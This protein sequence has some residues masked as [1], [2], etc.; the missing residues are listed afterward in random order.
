[1]D[2]MAPLWNKSKYGHGIRR[3]WKIL[4]LAFKKFLHIDGVQ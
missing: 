2:S 3:V 4:F 1:M